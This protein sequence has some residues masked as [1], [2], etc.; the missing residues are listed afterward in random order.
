[1]SD[2]AAANSKKQRKR[3]PS[4]PAVNLETAVERAQQLHL[5]ENQ[6][7]TPID[8][9]F[10]HWGYA[11]TAGNANLVIA[12]LRKFGLIDYEGS[13]DVRRARISDLAVRILEHPDQGKRREAL[14]EA[15]LLPIIHHE[16]WKKYGSKLPSDDSLRW[17][18]ERE[19][20]FSRTGA[21][22]FI[23]QYR[24]TLAFAGLLSDDTGTPQEPA[25]ED[26]DDAETPGTEDRRPQ[27]SSRHSRPEGRVSGAGGLTI[28]V[29]VVGGAPIYI[30]G[31]FP[32]TEEAWA[33]FLA[34]LQA[35]KPGLVAPRS[36]ASEDD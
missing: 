15:A 14:R 20:D 29:P 19:R 18:L 6:H 17:E 4:Y 21:T 36:D 34:V 32:V 33:Q 22:E 10:R 8:T 24:S 12:A 30:E 35:M 1:M 25:Q 31:Q 9:V 3:S 2:M 11:S 23:P 27:S 26:E 7:P 16:L 13:G 5:Q 28:P